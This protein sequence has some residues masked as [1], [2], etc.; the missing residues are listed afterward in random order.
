VVRGA[1]ARTVPVAGVGG[2]QHVGTGLPDRLG[3]SI[4]DIDRVVVA[5]ARVVVL[6]VVPGEEALAER[7]GVS[8]AAERVGE[9]GPI[10]QRL[11]VNT[12]VE[13]GWWQST[14]RGAV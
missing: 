6:G 9:V 14:G 12:N 4:V 5:D 2:G 13:G 1:Y 11:V 10:L 8:Q 3:T 7:A